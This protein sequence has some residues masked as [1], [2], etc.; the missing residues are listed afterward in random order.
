MVP[1][2]TFGIVTSGVAERSFKI[3]YNKHTFL[4][5][6]KPFRFVGGSMHYFRVPRA[7]WDDRLHTL[8]MGGPNVVDFYIDWSGHEPEPGQ[9]NFADNYDL[10]AFLEAVKKADLLAIVRP[11]PYIC[12]EVDNAGL[13]YWLLR[14][15]PDMEYRTMHDDYMLEM[16]KWFQKLLPMLVPYLYKNGGPIIMVQVS[17]RT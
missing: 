3:D 1:L 13:P 4:K 8:R 17:V 2:I 10:V 12:G 5:D 9:Y 15:H 11:G 6:G 14:K 7:Y 16:G